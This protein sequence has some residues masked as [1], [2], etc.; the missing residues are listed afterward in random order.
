[1]SEFLWLLFSLSLSASFVMVL[2]FTLTKLFKRRLD[3][4]WRY[5][6]WLI[7][8]VR[9]LVPYA[10][11]ANLMNLIMQESRNPVAI[12]AVIQPPQ[13]ENTPIILPQTEAPMISADTT[14]HKASM[15]TTNVKEYF[16]IVWAVVA[17][18]MLAWK[19]SSYLR[20]IRFSARKRKRIENPAVLST[21]QS[22]IHAL[23]LHRTPPLYKSGIAGVPMLIGLFR[24]YILIPDSEI[25]EQNLRHILMHELTH[26][27]RRDGFYKWLV[28]IVVCIHWF[29]PFI[30]F[31][32]R[33]IDKACEL[34]CDEAVLR[35]LNRSERRDYGE[36]LL[37]SLQCGIDAPNRV[38]T[39]PLS[40]DGRLL[41]T[42]LDSIMNFRRIGTGGIIISLLLTGCIG[43]GAIFSGAYYA[44]PNVVNPAALEENSHN[45]IPLPP[46]E[47]AA[48]PESVPTIEKPREV[49]KIGMQEIPTK[50]YEAQI[51]QREEMDAWLEGLDG[52]IY[53]DY[54]YSSPNM[55]IQVTDVAAFEQSS[56]MNVAKESGW[57]FALE[58]V[59]LS[60]NEID[61]LIT[62][63]L[64]WER[65]HEFQIDSFGAS[66]DKSTMS[67]RTT[68]L[69]PQNRAIIEEFV[70]I[71]PLE[72]YNSEIANE[73]TGTGEYR[74]VGLDGIIDWYIPRLF[75]K[76]FVY[77]VLVKGPT[78]SAFSNGD[79]PDWNFYLQYD[80]AVSEDQ[81]SD[82][83]TRKISEW[84]DMMYDPDKITYVIKRV[85][86][87][88]V[89]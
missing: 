72:F 62:R 88:R 32:A 3:H 75:D 16:G 58:E 77:N 7:V 14:S 76:P 1:M 45:G 33:E 49:V 18:S 73:V 39:L 87:E 64:N 89:N 34:S 19:L 86:V 11:E 70:G 4:T 61:A 43:M 30:Y 79:Q 78:M 24:P 23:K 44:P 35:R 25:Q 12:G 46:A 81:M 85:E 60:A 69:S 13:T 50:E 71:G 15:N 67:V 17:V 55:V 28:Q 65:R 2:I 66:D 20:F 22:A 8:I 68:S 36:M 37:T 29:N 9:L 48:T 56:D 10:P 57:V 54:Y 31:T 84:Y 52:N 21:Y 6:I 59:R 53:S 74:M 83:I 51:K 47:D 38:I 42:R 63:M 82:A 27:K 26:Y 80:S 40:K 41:K 5:Y